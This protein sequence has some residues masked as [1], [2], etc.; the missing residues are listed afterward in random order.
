MSFPSSPTLGQKY[1]AINPIWEWDGSVWQKIY[2]APIGY[3]GS[4]G[5]Q[6]VTGSQGIQGV[7]G[8]TGSQGIQGII[9]YSGSRGATGF[10]GSSGGL[11][12]TGSKGTPGIHVGGS[13]PSSPSVNDLWLEI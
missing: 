8:Y 2:I 7:I 12:Y 9:G 1:P 10:V 3:T 6:G 4:Q 11:G 13:A 5:I